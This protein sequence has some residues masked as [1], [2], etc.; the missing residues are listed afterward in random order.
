MKLNMTV[1]LCDKADFGIRQTSLIGITNMIRC[2]T[3]VEQKYLLYAPYLFLLD[4]GD[5]T[6]YRFS[7]YLR[8]VCNKKGFPVDSLAHL[9]DLTLNLDSSAYSE[10]LT[11]AQYALIE[12][13][14]QPKIREGNIA[15]DL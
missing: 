7:F 13:M 6:E 12:A 8:Y 3:A 1:K 9:D 4:E 15:F 5:R 2:K 14:S 10:I 11:V